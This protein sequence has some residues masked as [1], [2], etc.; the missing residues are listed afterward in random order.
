MHMLNL[1]EG[2]LSFFGG[3]DWLLVKCVDNGV[4]TPFEQCHLLI[5]D[6]CR[7]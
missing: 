5:L 2:P 6:T 3:V 7:I 1:H 4:L